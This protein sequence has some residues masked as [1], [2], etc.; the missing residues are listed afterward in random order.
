M[1]HHQNASKVVIHQLYIH[2]NYITL[3]KKWKL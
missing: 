1:N 2:L 3:Q